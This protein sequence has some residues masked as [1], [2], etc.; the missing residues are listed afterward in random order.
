[1]VAARKSSKRPKLRRSSVAARLAGV[2]FAALATVAPTAT[3][4]QSTPGVSSRPEPPALGVDR[5]SGP[6]V[7]PQGD[8]FPLVMMAVVDDAEMREVRAAGWNM[9][10]RYGESFNR[11]YI[12]SAAKRGLG[13]LA[14][15][16]GEEPGVTEEQ[17][18]RVIGGFAAEPGV[19]WWDLPEERRYWVAAEMEVL[20]AASRLSRE[21]DPQKRPRIAYIPGHYDAEGTAKYVPLIDLV[22]AS[23]YATY[24]EQ[25][26]AWVRW[27]MAQAVEAIGL[28]GAKVGR[29]YAGGEKTP[30]AYVELYIGAAGKVMTPAGIEHDVWAS[31]VAGARGIIVYSYHYRNS[32]PELRGCL[33][34]L[35]RAAGVLSAPDG[36]GSAIVLGTPE[37]GVRATVVDGPA[38]TEPFT[39]W[40]KQPV[41]VASLGVLAVRHRGVRWVIA[42]NSCTVPVRARVTGLEPMPRAE[43]VAG[44]GQETVGVAVPI[45]EGAMEIDL[46]ALGVRVLRLAEGKP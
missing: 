3:P 25:P 7:F 12:A 34:A 14:N 16:P 8:E 44:A 39:P 11:E 9:V 22:P 21:L 27:R 31:I 5:A 19:V 15:L 1:M 24:A 17:L 6:S 20:R 13:S 33:A 38:L 18:R 4:A 29:D 43:M 30:V 41:Q 35:N 42:V 37:P 2:T 23:V 46:P 32:R 28:A 36:V 26:H 10:H 40:R 45:H